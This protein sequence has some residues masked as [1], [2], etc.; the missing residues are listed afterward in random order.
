MVLASAGSIWR[1]KRLN[2]FGN[3][4]IPARRIEKRRI[5]LYVRFSPS[6]REVEDLLPERGIM[7]PTLCSRANTCWPGAA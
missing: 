5:R 1:A 6:F 3:F 2:H 7:C 4:R